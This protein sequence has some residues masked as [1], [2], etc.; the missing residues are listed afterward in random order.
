MCELCLPSIT[1]RR[2]LGLMGV[3]TAGALLGRPHPATAARSLQTGY[4]VAI[5]P[6][7]TWAGDD[8]PELGSM[9]DED[10][11]FLLVHHTAGPSEGDPIGLMRQ[12]Y[13]FHTGPDRGWPDV[14]YNFFVEPGGRVFEARAGSLRRAVEASAT[15]GSQGFAQLVCLLGDFTNRNPTDAQLRSLNETLAWLADRFGLDTSGGSTHDLH[16]AWIQQ[17]V[18]RIGGDCGHRLGSP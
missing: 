16:V 9:A 10:V 7:A 3:A 5:E 2:A 12:V 6:R 13:D 4:G 17:V 11:R 8:R 1:R 18:G 14:A 15:G